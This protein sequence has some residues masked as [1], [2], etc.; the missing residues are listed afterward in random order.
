MEKYNQKMEKR[1]YVLLLFFLMVNLGRGQQVIGSFPY[2]DGGFENQ[3]LGNLG[4]SL[5]TTNW[6]RQSQS[7]A[8]STIV[9]T[10]PRSG[11]KNGAVI[12]VSTVSRG[13]QSPQDAVAA[14]GPQA[15]KSYV[16][17]Y[18][19]RN[20]GSITSFQ[21]GAVTTNGTTNPS[22]YPTAAT[23]NANSNWTKQTL[24]ITN[25]TTAATT[26]GIGIAGRSSTGSFDVDDFVIY[27]G[28][29]VDNT[30]PSSAG[31]VSVSGAT[32]SSLAISWGLPQEV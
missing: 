10:S 6:S 19:I 16:I 28:A 4:T 25:S 27:A 9:S 18:Y 13:L 8:S 12:N 22:S 1:F 20:S 21:L 7:G 26:C 30:A 29:A 5:S 11:S 31:V 3:T 17:Q 2:M 24:V 14:N 23:L 15:S 32:T